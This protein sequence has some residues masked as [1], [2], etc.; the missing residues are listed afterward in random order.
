[1]KFRMLILAVAMLA[2][3]S[4]G[5]GQPAQW[6]FYWGDFPGGSPAWSPMLYDCDAPMNPVTNPVLK[7]GTI[8]RVMRGGSADGYLSTHLPYR[9]GNTPSGTPRPIDNV[10]SDPTLYGQPVEFPFNSAQVVGSS[11]G[12]FVAGQFFF[13]QSTPGE[14]LGDYLNVQRM[15]LQVGCWNADR[16]VFTCLYFTKRFA[17]LPGLTY[18]KFTDAYDSWDEENQEWVTIPGDWTCRAGTLCEIPVTVTCETDLEHPMTPS[19]LM[20][21]EGGQVHGD[22][23][24]LNQYICVNLCEGHNL[25]IR[26]DHLKIDELPIVNVL[27]GCATPT[28]CNEVCD[29]AT[30]SYS[31]AA[32]MWHEVPGTQYGYYTNTIFNV[33]LGGC[34]CVMLEDI[35]PVEMGAIDITPRDASVELSWTTLAE[36]SLNY[37]KVVRDGE[38]RA[39]I[40]AKAEVGLGANYSYTDEAR[41]GVTYSY[42][43]VAVEEDGSETVLREAEATPNASLAVITEYAL[44]QNYPNPFNP[45]TS[46]VFDVVESNHVTLTIYNAMGQEVA[47]LVN[48][49]Y[50]NGRHSVEFSSDNLTSGLYFY[51]VKIGNEFSATKKMLLV[52]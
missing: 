22:V 28:G 14:V 39:T 18:K 51:N 23:N 43:L 47:T 11:E 44:H 8:V 36:S 13:R 4:L 19:P 15:Y 21:D 17:V 30:F 31:P 9:W 50:G 7:D 2:V 16:S 41:N 24:D 12:S 46:I 25:E 45:T 32:W 29:A 33:T 5:F 27:A 34:A 48:G 10:S 38:V 20:I 42:S 40:N 49:T 52:K 1:M 35:L 26:I 6:F 37:F 3:T